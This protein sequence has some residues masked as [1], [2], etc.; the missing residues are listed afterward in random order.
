[1]LEFEINSFAAGGGDLL[2][3]SGDATVSDA[4]F[5]FDISGVDTF[6]T[7]DEIAFLTAGGALTSTIANAATF[8]GNDNQFDFAITEREVDDGAGCNRTVGEERLDLAA[9]RSVGTFAFGEK[10]YECGSCHCISSP[11]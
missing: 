11:P 4:A 10:L 3:I 2:D 9:V 7:G 5:V 8:I 1:M 6:T